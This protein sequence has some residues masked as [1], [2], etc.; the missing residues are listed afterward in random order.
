MAGVPHGSDIPWHRVINSAG[1]I[2]I[3]S[4]GEGHEVQRQLLESE[5]IIFDGRGRVDLG[6]FGWRGPEVSGQSSE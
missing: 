3:R 6:R 4:G 1:K 5:G 2:S